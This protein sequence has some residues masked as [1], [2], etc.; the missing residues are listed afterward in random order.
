MA[1]F[2]Y[3][4]ATGEIYHIYNRSVVGSELFKDKRCYGRFLDCIRYYQLKFPPQRLSYFLRQKKDLSAAIKQ[5][6]KLADV[7][8]YC[9]MPTHFH[10]IVKQLEDKGIA[11]YIN[12]LLNSY[13]RYYNTKYQRKGPL[14]EG[15]FRRIRISTEEQLLHLTRYIHLNPAT[16]YIVEKPET[17]IYSSYRE[18]LGLVGDKITQPGQVLG[19]NYSSKDYK[20]FVDVRRDYQRKIKEIKEILIEKNNA[21]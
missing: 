12:R 11:I 2:Q 21:V 4:L 20:Q 16:S 1:S 14:W 6:A 15:R 18:Y 10:L 13:S 3:I 19:P 7:L 5:K 17:F 8:C 9:L